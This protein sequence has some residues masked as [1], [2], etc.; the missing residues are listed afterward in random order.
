[1][2]SMH[3]DATAVVQRAVSLRGRPLDDSQRALLARYVDRLAAATAALNLTAVRDIPGI[4]RRHIAESLALL[5]LLEEH[6]LVPEGGR[7]IDIGSGGG[8]PGIPIAIARPDLRVTLLEAVGKKA[9]F[10]RDTVEALEL[11]RVDVLA[12][13]AEEAGRDTAH[14]ERYDVAVAR[15]VAPLNVLAE[16]ALPLVRLGGWLA[17]VKGS[18]VHAELAEAHEAISRCGGRVAAVFPLP[19]LVGAPL[20]VVLIRKERPTPPELPRRPGIPAKRP[21]R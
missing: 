18:K 7:L 10:L 5:R 20:S 19:T 6:G 15:A 21:L 2:V 16:L 13:R 14:R 3:P 17:A 11:P 8:L 9:A 12:V 1:M 4:Y